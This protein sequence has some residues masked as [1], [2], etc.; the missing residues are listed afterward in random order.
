[1]G[2]K[3]QRHPDS[4]TVHQPA[5]ARMSREGPPEDAQ[6]GGGPSQLADQEL[7]LHLNLSPGL[8]SLEDGIP[9]QFAQLTSASPS[10][11][12]PAVEAAE[13]QAAPTASPAILP[14]EVE[15]GSFQATA[16]QLVMTERQVSASFCPETQP[17]P[18]LEACDLHLQE[19]VASAACVANTAQQ[20]LLYP[21]T[22]IL[23]Y[24]PPPMP[25]QPAAPASAGQ[26][27]AAPSQPPGMQPECPEPAV[28]G[29][30][31]PHE[32]LQARGA[33]T[34]ATSDEPVQEEHTPLPPPH[35][36]PDS[37]AAVA[38]ATADIGA[39]PRREN[40]AEQPASLEGA[41][42]AST[43][44]AARAAGAEQTQEGARSAMGT[45]ATKSPSRRPTLS[46][47]LSEDFLSESEG[48]QRAVVAAKIIDE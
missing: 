11:E 36:E 13:A 37:S 33:Q 27:T 17:E 47:L 14:T 42:E 21:D 28:S 26:P 12:A 24:H 23:E 22:Q 45:P 30:E 19:P 10:M 32:V 29:R 5:A 43:S 38:A 18:A 1:M 41:A 31:M 44:G 16:R 35:A 9:R 15:P 25:A 7:S 48:T 8:S 34:D 4:G 39:E 46:L 20:P 40:C 3:Q 6:V 2:A